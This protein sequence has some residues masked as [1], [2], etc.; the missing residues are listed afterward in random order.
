LE[1]IGQAAPQRHNRFWLKAQSQTCY[2]F[3]TQIQHGR[4]KECTHRSLPGD[5][6]GKPFATRLPAEGD[7]TPN[8]NALKVLWTDA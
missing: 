8:L 4:E 1:T 6:G 2:T 7:L 5:G 3:R